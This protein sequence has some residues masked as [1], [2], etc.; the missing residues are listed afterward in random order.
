MVTNI[1]I[2]IDNCDYEKIIAAKGDMT[3]REVLFEW[4]HT[5]TNTAI[6][7]KPVR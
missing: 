6:S 4:Y 5:K 1:N 2:P 7:P 3:W